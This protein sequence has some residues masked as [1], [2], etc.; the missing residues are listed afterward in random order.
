M[1]MTAQHS[2]VVA[3]V[4]LASITDVRTRRI[5]N[6]LTFGA[7]I[8]ALL[9]HVSTGGTSGLTTSV[10]GWM[11]GAALFFPVF[12]LRGMGAGDVK[13]LAAV[14]AWLGPL[15]VVWV[16]LVTTIAGGAI[17]L[18]VSLVHGYLRTALT[19]L[20]MLLMHWRISGIQPL[21]AVTLEGGTRPATGVCSADCDWD[22]DNTMAQILKTPFS[23]WR[24]EDGAQLVEFALVLPMLLL[25]VLGIAEFGFIFQ[26]YEVVTN[27]AREGARI[28][29]LPGYS[30]ADVQ[31][32]VAAYV[33]AGRVPTTGT[34]PVIAVT[35]VSIPT[36][37]GG[38]VLTAKR[39]TVTYLHTYM[40]L[41]GIGSWFGVTYA[42]VPLT[43]VSEMRTE[44]ATGL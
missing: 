1:T 4:A 40:F 19:N 39:V 43:A 26:R 21:P 29:S 8:A 37:P 10:G 41:T 9:F 25:V 38:P 31:A 14:G 30:N 28:A 16:A 18:V 32:R 34:N 33:T 13:L 7:T 24:S 44:I 17:A 36:T 2:V 23:R 5:P 20:L 42:T 22:G 11:L 35:D 3:L 15:P 27:A 12:A 6:V